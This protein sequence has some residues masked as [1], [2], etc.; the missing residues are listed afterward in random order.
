MQKAIVL[1]KAR[2]HLSKQEVSFELYP[3]AVSGKAESLVRRCC[4][5][6]GGWEDSWVLKEK[7][8]SIRAESTF[9]C[10]CL[11]F[12]TSLACFSYCALVK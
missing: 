12:G 1:T 11:A 9:Q 2:E 7:E 4:D 8:G 5:L 3:N 6:S 10:T